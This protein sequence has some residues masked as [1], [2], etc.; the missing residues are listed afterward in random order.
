MVH[1]RRFASSTLKALAPAGATGGAAPAL[2]RRLSAPA[3]AGVLRGHF[4]EHL[5]LGPVLG[6]R[7]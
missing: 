3:L 7:R 6:D 2:P 5:N 1:G 4:A